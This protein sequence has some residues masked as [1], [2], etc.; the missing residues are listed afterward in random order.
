MIR[1][2]DVITELSLIDDKIGETI[3]GAKQISKMIG[4]N[5]ILKKLNLSGNCFSDKSVK[6]LVEALEVS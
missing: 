6:Y 2:N 1:K 5:C 4:K 3:E